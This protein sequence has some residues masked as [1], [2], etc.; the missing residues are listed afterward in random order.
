M[1][2]NSRSN[3]TSAMR[4][5][6]LEFP[7]SKRTSSASGAKK[8][9]V[10]PAKRAVVQVSSPE[11]T[12][13]AAEISSIALKDEG[14]ELEK[15][16]IAPPKEQTLQG[17][18]RKKPIPEELPELNIRDPRWRKLF[19]DAKAKRGGLPLGVFRRF[20]NVSAV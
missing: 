7:S 14:E 18:T 9:V 12:G 6:K 10:N 3:S 13:E 11:E 16:S 15:M 19:T 8:T 5:I 17:S 4:Q 20:L 2:S 1:S